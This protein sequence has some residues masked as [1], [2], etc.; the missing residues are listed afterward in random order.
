MPASRNA[1]ADLF[2]T[3][4]LEEA[5]GFLRIQAHR[6][7]A[8]SL[9]RDGV[10]TSSYRKD[11]ETIERETPYFLR[12]LQRHHPL[13]P[14]AQEVPSRTTPATTTCRRRSGRYPLRTAPRQR[15]D[16]RAGLFLGQ[17]IHDA[18]RAGVIDRREIAGLFRSSFR[19][20]A[21]ALKTYLDLTERVRPAL[22]S[23]S[24]PQPGATG[25]RDAGALTARPGPPS[26]AVRPPSAL[27]PRHAGLSLERMLWPHPLL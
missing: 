25:R 24:T 1:P 5:L 10:S 26:P 20:S 13:H 14:A 3:G 9:L 11:R 16:P 19:E 15:P 12:G 8:Q 18:Y 17:Q 6:S 7:G 27:A 2:Y 4:V 23:G 22:Q 21:S